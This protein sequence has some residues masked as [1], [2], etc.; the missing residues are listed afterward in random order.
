MHLLGFHARYSIA[1]VHWSAIKKIL[2]SNFVRAL[3]LLHS[4]GALA[5]KRVYIKIA[6][7]TYPSPTVGTLVK[8]PLCLGG[9][10]VVKSRPLHKKAELVLTALYF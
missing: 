8:D 3:L 7:R 2:N 4:L 10:R 5:K 6:G 1:W 9:G